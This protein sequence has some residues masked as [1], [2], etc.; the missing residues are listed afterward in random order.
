[1]SGAHLENAAETQHGDYSRKSI[2][3]DS[4]LK[5]R[6][7][8]VSLAALTFSSMVGSGWLFASYYAAQAAGPLSIVSW[9]I[10]IVAIALVALTFIELGVSRP[11]S[12]GNV[13]WPSMVSGPFVG[14]VIGWVIF[15]QSAVGTPSE[16]SALLQYAS[17]WWPALFQNGHLTAVGL[18]FGAIIL[19]VFTALNW[20]GVVLLA[21][22]N[23]L[24]VI[25][26]IAVPVLTVILLL[27]AG[28]D[29]YTVEAG[30]GFAPYGT[31]AMLTA[32]IGA[33]LLYSF[34]GVQLSSVMAGEAR[35]PRRDVPIGTFVGFGAAALLYLLLQISFLSAVP[36]E[37]LKS[38]GWSG[39]N[40]ESPFVQLAL[41]INMG[42]LAQ[43]LMV[44]ALVSPAGGLFVGAGFYGRNTYALGR[45]HTL[46]EWV[47]KVHAKSGI[48]RNAML[49]NLVLAIV[50]LLV[51]QSWQ[52]LVS[53]LGMFFALGFAATAVAAGA[54]RH[55]P[56]MPG[57]GF[58]RAIVVISP[59]AFVIAGLIMYWASWQKVSMALVLAL[60]AIPLYFIRMLRDRRHLSMAGVRAGAWFVCFIV[61]I[62]ALSWIGE[63][64]G[65]GWIAQP[66]DSILAGVASF[67][68]YF[69]GL[70][71]SKRWLQSHAAAR[72][73]GEY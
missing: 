10:C 4:L 56:R 8:W 40:F 64:G 6:L 71:S 57:K 59:A 68:C 43:L 67:G 61:V 9:L 44:D 69:W 46:P 22:V 31:G 1:M 5:R 65:K 37:L 30:G 23:S 27:A 2:D 21:R 34:G 17:R 41:F 49:L 60:L 3:Q 7:T 28:F 32:I 73:F 36:H 14:V 29:S 19:V 25:F 20:F 66:W 51:F 18:V 26:K 72:T 24:I 33:G 45:N 39:L 48:P 70:I 58:T 12:G 63:Y 50:F 54:N 62:G 13:R 38:V 15:L 52:N 55:D 42:W 16:A 47:G 11:V 53:A 35:K